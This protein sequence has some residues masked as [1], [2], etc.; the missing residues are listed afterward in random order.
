MNAE[1][2]E[3]DELFEL[4]AEFCCIFGNASRLKIIWALGRQEKSVGELAERVGA[5]MSSVSQHLR[6]MKD[7][8]IVRS[9]KQGQK[10]F[11]RISNDK[12]IEAPMLLREGIMEIHGLDRRRLGEPPERA[13]PESG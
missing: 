12:F 1:E 10:I 5:S 2:R 3:L 6:M 11:Y 4:Q 9:R 7:R 13:N 8:G